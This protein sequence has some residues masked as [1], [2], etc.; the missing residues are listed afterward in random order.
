MVKLRDVPM[1]A[2]TVNGLSAIATNIVKPLMLDSFTCTMCNESWGRNSYARTMIKVS[3]ENTLNDSIV[4][5]FPNL[6]DD[7]YVYEI[8][9]IEYEWIPP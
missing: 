7:G 9:A 6:D 3:A 2:L 4:I 1:V 5:S 8:I